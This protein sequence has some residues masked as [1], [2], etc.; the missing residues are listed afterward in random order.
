MTPVHQPVPMPAGPAAGVPAG[1]PGQSPGDAATAPPAGPAPQVQGAFD[2]VFAA[3]AA[4]AASAALPAGQTAEPATPEGQ[5]DHAAEAGPPGLPLPDSLLPFEAGSPASAA[6]AGAMTGPVPPAMPEGPAELPGVT[7]LAAVPPGSVTQTPPPPGQPGAIAPDGPPGPTGSTGPQGSAAAPAPAAPAPAAGMP[8]AAARTST[9]ADPPPGT[10]P[11]PAANLAAS[12]AEPRRRDTSTALAAGPDALLPEAAAEQSPLLQTPGETRR[13]ETDITIKS[14]RA[15]PEAPPA[16]ERQIVAALVA[17]GSGR[18]EILLDPQDLGRVRLAL[19]GGEGG[20]VV[21]IQAERAE[22]ADLL[23][24][25]SDILREEFRAAG[26]TEMTFH[27]SDRDSQTD[28]PDRA[29]AGEDGYPAALVETDQP[30]RQP[31]GPVLRGTALLDL[32]L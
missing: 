21:T 15:G 1:Y 13:T 29:E 14:L 28:W 18:I 31:P 3:M 2:T 23:R 24:R 19:E 25:N 12:D 6:P 20:L 30:T 5:P 7:A 8:E 4:P 27:F 26:Y 10:T 17:S 22:T 11:A 16:A 9:P 32:R